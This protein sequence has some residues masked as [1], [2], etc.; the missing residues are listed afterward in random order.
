MKWKLIRRP[1]LWSTLVLAMWPVEIGRA[2]VIGTVVVVS[3]DVQGAPPGGRFAPMRPLDEI[4]SGMTIATGEDSF[5]E[6]TLDPRAVSLPETSLQLGPNSH[7]VVGETAL[8][9]VEGKVLFAFFRRAR[10]DVEIRTSTAILDNLSTSTFVGISAVTSDRTTVSAFE[11]PIFVRSTS[12]GSPLELGT[13]LRTV[14]EEGGEPSPPTP[15][16]PSDW[17]FSGAAGGPSFDVPQE[18]IG[19]PVTIETPDR[20]IRGEHERR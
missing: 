8:S 3:K 6:L 9:E 17:T 1:L 5:A 15:I 20:T 7:V 18:T 2:Q 14:V 13:G 19:P 12:G 4:L 11:G 16:D 10:A